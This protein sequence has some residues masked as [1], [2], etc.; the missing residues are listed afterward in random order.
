MGFR[1]RAEMCDTCIFRPGNPMHL[2]AG[3]VASM[4]AECRRDDSHIVCHETLNR[5]DEDVPGDDEAVCRGFINAGHSSQI[6]RI[7]ERLS[8]VVEV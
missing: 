3:R 8:M 7:A 6:L 1:I 4:V 2:K 5:D